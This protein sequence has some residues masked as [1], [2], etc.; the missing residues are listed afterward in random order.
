SDGEHGSAIIHGSS[1]DDEANVSDGDDATA[2]VNTDDEAE[3]E[4]EQEQRE[5]E[6]KVAAV[7]GKTEED[8]CQ[9]DLSESGPEVKKEKEDVRDEEDDGHHRQAAAAAAQ[10]RRPSVGHHDKHSEP[11]VGA[12]AKADA[13]DAKESEA[14]V[15][16]TTE[17]EA[18][19]AQPADESA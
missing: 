12:D 6:E 1:H 8:D 18:A 13:D 9:S 2:V 15:A 7:E 4:Q 16:P 14:D 17:E 19:D 11:A 5:G 3:Q 10:E